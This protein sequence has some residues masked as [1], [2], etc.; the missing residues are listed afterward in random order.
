MK[1]IDMAVV[2]LALALVLFTVVYN[3]RKRRR[4]EINCGY[5]SG[6]GAGAKDHG[7]DAGCCGTRDKVGHRE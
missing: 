4:G 7:K 6:C 5:C 2:V 3:V 1:G